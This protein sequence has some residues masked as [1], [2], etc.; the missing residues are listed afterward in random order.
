MKLLTGLVLCVL[1]VFVFPSSAADSVGKPVAQA[2]SAAPMAEL[3]A[4][5]ADLVKSARARDRSFVTVDVV[6]AALAINAN[7]A[8]AV[9]GAI[10]RAVPEM[11]S[12]AAGKAAELLPKRA[13]EIARAAASAAPSKAGKIAAAVCRAAPAEYRNVAV[14]IAQVAPASGMD[15]LQ[16]VAAVFPELKPAI[17]SVLAANRT[18]APAVAFV[19]DS[20][21]AAA[22]D[23]SGA[24]ASAAGAPAVRGPAVAP[25]YVPGSGSSPNVTPS[26]SGTVPRG[27]RN[28]ASP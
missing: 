3:P 7:T 14:A 9:V 18:S 11:A 27:G 21:K 26:T 13:R 10:A 2:L 20:A 23:N 24:L 12:I 16:E 15:I 17:D 5:S 6:E 28:Y 22:P 4:K 19:L 1:A 25:P 8:P